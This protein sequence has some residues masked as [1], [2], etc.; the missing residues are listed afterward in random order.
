MPTTVDNIYAGLI[1]DCLAGESITTRNSTVKRTIA[2]QFTFT[3]TPLIS[4]RRTAWRNSLRELEWFLSGS[5]NLSDLHQSVHHWWRPWVN[6][7]GV[8]P[9]NYSTQF[10][11]FSGRR[12]TVDQ[13]E[14]MIDAIKNH[15]FSRRTV[16]TTWN[17]ADMIDSIT[18]ITNCWGTII[19]AFVDCD[20]RLSLV[21]YQRSC[22]VVVGLGSNWFQMWAFL[23]WCAR[24][25]GRKVGSLTW[26]GG[27]IHVYDEHAEIAKQI[28]KNAW[29]CDE[30]PTLVDRGV[31]DD[32][33]AGDFSLEGEYKV[34]LD[35]TAKM[36]V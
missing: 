19:Q 3:T 6:D 22:D 13:I 21:T 24:R 35:V 34:V 29:R 27:D 31:A 28:V 11:N 32:F 9:N 20:D 25:S 26:I 36:I 4:V 15:P 1:S 8:I 17:T 2:K 7:S 16:I 5:N 18:P 23:L 14:Y 10:R 12:G 33:R 30:T